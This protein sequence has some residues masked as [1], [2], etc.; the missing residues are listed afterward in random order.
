MRKTMS[1][2]EKELKRLE[3]EN[4]KQERIKEVKKS[5]SNVPDD[6]LYKFSQKIEKDYEGLEIDDAL[7]LLFK[8]FNKGD[9]KFI[10]KRII[11]FD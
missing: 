3:R 11:E 6:V 8:K 5:L 7:N 4:E 10:A 9:F 2:E 1:D